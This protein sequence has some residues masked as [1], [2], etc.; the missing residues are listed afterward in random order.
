MQLPR[1][2]RNVNDETS[3][4]FCGGRKFDEVEQALLWGLLQQEPQCPSRVLLAKAAEQHVII[5]VSLRQVNRWRAAQGLGRR[6]GR[7]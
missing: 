7:P 4:S 2:Q 3:P 5:T 1:N 6:K